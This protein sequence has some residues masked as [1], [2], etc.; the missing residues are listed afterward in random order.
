MDQYRV[1]TKRLRVQRGAGREDLVVERPFK[2]DAQGIVHYLDSDEAPTLVKFDKYCQVNVDQ[3]L[4]VGAIAK[5]KTAPKD[6]E[7]KE[8]ADG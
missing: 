1:L 3:L 5:L 2:E 7:P 6:A 4:R 8:A